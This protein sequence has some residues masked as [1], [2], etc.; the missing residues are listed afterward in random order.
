MT[1]VVAII[2]ARTGST[3]LP[4]KVLKSISGKSALERLIE[5]VKRARRIDEIII[6]TTSK[7]VDDVIVKLAGRLK[8]KVFRGSEND[9]LDRYFE[10][11]KLY[12]AE[13]IVRITGDCPLI[14]PM[15]IDRVVGFYLRQNNLYD[16]VSNVHPPTF[17][18]GMDVEVFSFKALE[19]AWQEARLPSE[20]EH[21]T[22]YIWK[23]PDCFR[24]SNVRSRT[25]LP[26]LRFTLDCPQDLVFIRKIFLHFYPRE[27]NF[28][29]EDIIFFLE[30]KKELKKINAGI[31]RNEGFLKSLRKDKLLGR[32][33]RY[34]K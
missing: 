24:L 32:T 20:R 30:E 13:D 19:K 3:R 17:P 6:A 7:K 10:A 21:V 25:K 26:P 23:R 27:K 9:V 12:G 4:G 14:D 5:R 1:R 29:L 18:D 28:T 8:I 34:K 22:P 11:A 33:P 16:Y 2:Q 15:V 31:I